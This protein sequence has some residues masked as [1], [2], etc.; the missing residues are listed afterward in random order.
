MLRQTSTTDYM[1]A[2]SSMKLAS[3]KSAS[4]NEAKFVIPHHNVNQTD[5]DLILSEKKINEY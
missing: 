2:A 1:S 5:K 4:F 3:I